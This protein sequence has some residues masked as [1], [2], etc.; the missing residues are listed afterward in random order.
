ML[1]VVDP[2]DV[3]CGSTDC[4]CVVHNLWSYIPH[5]AVSVSMLGVYHSISG[6][7]KMPTHEDLA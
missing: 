6:Y 4:V 1:D 3:V 7:V 2:L 5:I